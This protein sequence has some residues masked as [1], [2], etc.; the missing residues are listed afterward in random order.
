MDYATLHK[1]LNRAKSTVHGSILANLDNL[2]R[3]AIML[4]DVQ[5][6]IRHLKTTIDNLMRSN[7]ILA[8][9]KKAYRSQRCCKW[10]CSERKI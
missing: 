9:D 7:A 2:I 10:D 6:E 1:W 8:E 5:G 4:D 3:A